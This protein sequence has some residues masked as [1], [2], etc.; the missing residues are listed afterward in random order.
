MNSA[1]P[2]LSLDKKGVGIL[3]SYDDSIGGGLQVN[4]ERIY[5]KTEVDNLV[6]GSLKFKAGSV[7]KRIN[8][9]SVALFTLNELKTLFNTSTA[10]TTNFFALVNNGDGSAN[11][12]HFENCTWVGTTLYVVHNGTVNTNTKI[13]YMIFY[14]P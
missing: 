1:K 11:S 4:G 2:T 10:G 6:S 13:N 7:V 3:C 9:D 14:I 5:N 12:R 8:G